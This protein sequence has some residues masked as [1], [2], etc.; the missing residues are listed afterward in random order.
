MFSFLFFLLSHK[1]RFSDKLFTH[2]YRLYNRSTFITSVNMWLHI[3]SVHGGIYHGDEGKA[4]HAGHVVNSKT[5]K[6]KQWQES[7]SNNLFVNTIN[8]FLFTFAVIL[9][10]FII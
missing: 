3:T 9:T 4:R 7:C 8:I 1:L 6:Q 2:C 5:C 10:H